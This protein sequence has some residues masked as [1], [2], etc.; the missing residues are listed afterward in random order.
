MQCRYCSYEHVAGLQV[1]L[2]PVPWTDLGQSRE[3]LA[4]GLELVQGGTYCVTVRANNAAELSTKKSVPGT[5]QKG[6]ARDRSLEL[7]EFVFR[8]RMLNAWG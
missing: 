5:V 7:M 4:T 3:A 8:I 2:E 1:D 6:T